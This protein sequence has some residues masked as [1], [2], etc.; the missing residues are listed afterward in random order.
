MSQKKRKRIPI[1]DWLNNNK[2]VAV[3]SLF[4]AVVI[5]LV[6]ALQ[7]SDRVE[8]TLT[9]IPVTFDTTMTDK[10]G[11]QMFGQTD[12]S[13]TV[14]VTGKRHEI[15]TAVLSQDDFLVSASTAN[16]TS[17]DR[18]TLPITVRAKDENRDIQIV[19]FSPAS[20]DIYFDY[21]LT[22]NFPVEVQ[23]AAKDDQISADGYI[24]GEPLVSTAEVTVSGAAAEVQ[25]IAR[26][27][28]KV[29][30]TQPL[31]ETTKFEKTELA[32]VNENGGTVRSTYVQ[33]ADGM[34]DVTVTVPI[35]K[36]TQIKPTVRFKNSPSYFLEHP[37]S[38]I[39]SPSGAVEAAVPTELLES[40]DSLALGTIDFSRIKTGPNTF[41]FQAQ[42]IP[43]IRVLDD[44]D[45]F[46]VYFSIDGFQSRK[47]TIPADRI[48]LSE[49][50]DDAAV[51]IPE[52]TTLEVTVIGHAEE[53]ETLTA[54]SL[55]A[56]LDAD[57]L[58]A[59]ADAES[60]PVTISVTNTTSCWVSG[61]Y[62]VPITIS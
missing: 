24:E 34:K 2:F 51:S 17:A 61:S 21:N 30:L 27:L 16:V 50:P 47:F 13:V 62:T 20:V 57:A 15:S 58:E 3:L 44:I 36:V 25:K 33:V 32:I 43:N 1:G 49:L 42:D 19:S 37:I 40:T 46:R 41:E 23:I 60:L 56:T 29:T 52:N 45:S 10:L 53:L 8:A 35:L 26:V 31:S 4:L 14:T 18:Y 5:W 39:C 22:E 48:A 11:L 59:D 28:A 54:D 55:T 12:L 38:V 7:F 9:D 6:V